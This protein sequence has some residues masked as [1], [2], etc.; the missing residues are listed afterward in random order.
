MVQP[1]KSED[2]IFFDACLVGDC[3][4]I[5]LQLV[6]RM[7][8]ILQTD[9]SLH[10]KKG[11]SSPYESLISSFLASHN[12]KGIIVGEPKCY[13]CLSIHEKKSMAINLFNHPEEKI[14]L[15]PG[16]D[17]QNATDD[18]KSCNSPFHESVYC[19]VCHVLILGRIMSCST[20][21]D[22]DLCPSCFPSNHKIHFD[23]MHMFIEQVN[24]N[25]L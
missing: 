4:D 5:V 24:A 2:E 6:Q 11:P 25:K 15:F 3:D 16:Y 10:K 9:E 12:P 17:E 22:Y 7:K 21:F 20:C 14:L 23:G 8:M 18:L 13:S 19:D 1:R